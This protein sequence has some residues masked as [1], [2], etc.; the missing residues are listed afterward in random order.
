MLENIV[1]GDGHVE[2]L[3]RHSRL[4]LLSMCGQVNEGMK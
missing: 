1:L 4:A 3:D 2:G